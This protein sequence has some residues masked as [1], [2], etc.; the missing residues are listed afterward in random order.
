MAYHYTTERNAQI[1]ISLLKE[2]GIKRIVASPGSTNANIVISMQQDP[3]FEIYSAADERSAAYMSC[4]IAEETGEPVVISCTGA[5]A[6]RNYIPG[7]TEAFYRKL[8]I[9]AVTSIVHFNKV[10][11]L[12]P[13]TLDRSHIQKDIAKESV[14]LS[15]VL[16][17]EDEYLTTFKVNKALNALFMDGGGP[18]HIN[19]ETTYSYDFS[20]KEL[21]KAKV[22]RKYTQNCDLPSL[23]KGR[24]AIFVGSH[25]K[26]T[27][28]ETQ[29]ID[30]FCAENDSVVFCDHSSGYNGKYKFL[31]ALVGCQVG[32]NKE[33]FSSELAIHIG[34]VS[35]NYPGFSSLRKSKQAWRISEDGEMRDFASNLTAIFDMPEIVFFK[36]YIRHSQEKKDTYFNQCKNLYDGLFSSLQKLE[37]PFSNGWIASKLSSVIP[38]GSSIFLGILNSLRNWNFFKLPSSVSS[39]S[40]VGGFG[41]DGGVSTMVGASLVNPNKLCF[42][43]FGDLAFFYDLNVL[44]NRHVGNNLRIL[45]INNGKGAEFRMYS[46]LASRIGDD[47]DNY[48]AAA[49][50]YGNKSQSL[51]Q[52]FAMD[53]GYIYLHAETKED[54]LSKYKDFVNP[55]ITKSIIF[56]VFTNSEDESDALKM[57]DHLMFPENQKSKKELVKHVIKDLLGENN[58]KRVINLLNK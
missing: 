56:E 1:L 27:K 45:L 12:M 9:V 32:Y 33:I 3:F 35:G 42:G 23:P 53:S 8:P 40:N 48:V 55:A 54:F 10:G 46:H 6:S 17:A 22:I 36:S 58:V 20:A 43:I 38:E 30:L 15:K 21:P 29:I 2:Y 19:I 51:I 28:E 18:V 41:I 24:I 34:E 47:A 25:K 7:L 52:H 4:G 37:L 26:F 13:Q 5:T 50:H 11:H 44:L 14:H 16:N 57:I 49:G 39:S 31:C